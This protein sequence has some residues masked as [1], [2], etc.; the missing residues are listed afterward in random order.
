MLNSATQEVT[1]A[2]QAVNGTNNISN[3][4]TDLFISFCLICI[5]IIFVL[6]LFLFGAT[7]LN[8]RMGKSQEKHRKYIINSHTVNY[9][10]ALVKYSPFFKRQYFN[11]SP[12]QYSTEELNVSTRNLLQQIPAQKHHCSPSLA[13]V[14]STL[15]FRDNGIHMPKRQTLQNVCALLS[16]ILK[17]LGSSFCPGHP[18]HD[19][20]LTL[21][22]LMW[23]RVTGSTAPWLEGLRGKHLAEASLWCFES[24]ECSC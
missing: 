11:Q 14:L 18:H 17:V 20:P 10:Q 4:H 13:Q 3:L 16:A 7:R 19:S 2:S 21:V 9:S 6:C 1:L 8:W 22:G 24:G 12:K 15:Q 5:W 23:G